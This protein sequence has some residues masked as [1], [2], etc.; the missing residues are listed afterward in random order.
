MKLI[1]M[2]PALTCLISIGVLIACQN[3]TGQ[4]KSN[5]NGIEIE[6]NGIFG[7]QKASAE[8]IKYYKNGIVG[9][10]IAQADGKKSICTGSLISSQY[11][12]TAGHCFFENGN[13]SS[14]SSVRV[15]TSADLSK[16]AKVEKQDYYSISSLMVHPRFLDTNLQDDERFKSD[17]AI[18]KLTYPVRNWKGSI[19][20]LPKEHYPVSEV[21]G[22]YVAGY[23][24][25]S[26]SN[27]EAG[28]N[29]KG[30][31]F[32]KTVGIARLESPNPELLYF[33]QRQGYGAC[34]GDSGGPVFASADN[35]E[36]LM[37]VISRAVKADS[38]NLCVGELHAVSTFALR[39][40]ILQNASVE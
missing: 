36:I 34:V 20:E 11:I 1:S 9:I 31:N 23:G 6:A 39:N 38:S 35:R 10:L 40:W 8:Q 19:F 26:I 22:A 37:G 33:N 14:E 3:P 32:L 29:V 7:G 27:K 21:N 2:K 30:D 12:L 17:L 13:L 18:L 16:S 28:E 15:V 25:E 24:Y 5:S 4:K